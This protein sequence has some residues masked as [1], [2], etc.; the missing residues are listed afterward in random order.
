MVSRTEVPTRSAGAPWID[1]SGSVTRYATLARRYSA[2][3]RTVPKASDSAMFRFGSFTSPAVNV[4]LFH[5]SEENSDPVWLTH[6]ATKRPKALAADTP[7]AMGS[8]L[9]GAQKSPKFAATVSAFQPSS[10]ARAIS[11]TSAPVLA[12]VN[13]FCTIFPYSRPR[14]FVHVRSAM[15][16]MPA[17]CAVDSEMAYPVET[18]TGGIR[19]RSSA[20]HGNRTPLKRANATATAA[21]VPL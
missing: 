3:T 21:M 4:M 18:C 14:V 20:T 13:T 6:N 2:I 16:P 11:P 9:R 10:R 15:R 8:K 1:C 19:Y 7:G 17:S 5:A 12:V